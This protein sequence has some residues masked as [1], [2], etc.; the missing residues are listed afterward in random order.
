MEEETIK[1]PR[2]FHNCDREAFLKIMVARKIIVVLAGVGLLLV[3][4]TTVLLVVMFKIH[5]D[6]E[7]STG[8]S[9]HS[10]EAP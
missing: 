3:L 2:P 1:Q 4:V 9:D 7:N 6:T 5:K 8:K 10:H